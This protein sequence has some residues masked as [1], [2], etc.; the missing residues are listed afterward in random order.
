MIESSYLTPKE[1]AG[2]ID[3][4]NLKAFLT[5]EDLKKLCDD[6]DRFGCRIVAINSYPVKFCKEYLKNS[7]VGVGAAISF[8][9]GQTTIETKVQETINAIKD[10]ADEIDYVINIGKAKEHNYEYIR[11][12]M[13]RIV[14]VCKDNNVTV[15]AIFENCYLTDE[16]KIELCHVAREVQ[17]DYIKTSTGFG[18]GGATLEDVRLMVREVDGK[19]KVK[20]ASGIRNLKDALKFIEAGAERLGTSAAETIIRQFNEKE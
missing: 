16:E 9:L 4:A 12:E 19:V 2:Y 10:G 20:A 18:S 5:E 8:P 6:A 14:K 1:L 17:P 13:Q 7:E 11:E 15:K 3:H